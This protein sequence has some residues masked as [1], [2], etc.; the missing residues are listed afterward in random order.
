MYLRLVHA[1]FQQDA[2]PKI[3]TV[4]DTKIIPRLQNT[5]GCLCVCAIISEKHSGEGISMTIWDTQTHAEAYEKSGTY[6]ELL[7]EVR[8]YLSDASEWKM[9]LSESL[10]LEYKPVTEDPVIK[11]Y[12]AA[13]QTDERIPPHHQT[14]TLYLRI[15]SLKTHPGMMEEF[16]LIYTND[17][18][19]EI[20]KQE[21]CRFAFLTENT[22]KE[23]EFLSITLWD[24]K[25]DADAYEKNKLYRELT[26]KVRHTLS[27]W[28]QWKMALEKEYGG[29]VT[30]SEDVTVDTYKVITGKSFQ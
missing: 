10:E 3:R 5:E 6:E 11:T 18:I 23:D 15:I 26:A 28:Y 20:R 12:V 27:G 30:T 8:P 13:A 2:L 4:Y 21:G 16:K 1:N 9:Q 7:D 24:S 14:D 17:I 22:K 25:A 29:R 19:L